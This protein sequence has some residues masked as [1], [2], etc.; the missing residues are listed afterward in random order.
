MKLEDVLNKDYI[1]PDLNSGEKREILEEMVGDLSTKVVGLNKEELLELI[2]ER[3]KL[4]STGIGYGVAIPHA[5]MKGIKNILVSFAR[6]RK[7][8]DFQSTDEKP[9]HLFFL[10]VAPENATSSHLK[11]L[12]EI[13][14][15]LRESVFRKKLLKA[16]DTEEIYQA[17][18]EA[19]RVL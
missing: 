16:R 13:S 19:D 17:I 10:I 18:M 8:I 6:S 12:S 3:E 15:I 11:I 14:R 1:I 4:G 9:V 5:K 2:L 7:G